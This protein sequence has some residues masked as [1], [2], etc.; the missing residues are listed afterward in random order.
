[1]GVM[2][3]CFSPCGKYVVSASRDET[4]RLWRTTRDSDGSCVRTCSEH[5]RLVTHVAFSPDRKILSSCAGDGT[6]VI[7]RMQDIVQP[8]DK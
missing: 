3:A 1:M 4:V 8:V 5:E 6:V 7:R 2:R